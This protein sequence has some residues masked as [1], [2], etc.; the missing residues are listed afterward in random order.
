MSVWDRV[1]GQEPVIAEF[2][3]AVAGAPD[4]RAMTHAWLVTGPPG[5]GRSVAA[6]AFA[7]ALVCPSGGC[8][9]CDSC[10]SVAAGRH[11]DVA[12]V[13]PAGVIMG[14]DQTRALVSR[15][16]VM[17]GRSDWNVVVIEDADRLNEHADNALLKSLE[18]PPDHGVW[19]LC[20]PSADD[21]LPTIR[22]RCRVVRLRTPPIDEVARFLRDSLGADPALAAYAARSSQGHIGRARAL[23]LD[24]DARRQHQVVLH[25]PQRLGSVAACLAAAGDLVAAARSRAEA[26]ADPL[27][28]AEE[29]ELLRAYGDG[30]TGA[31]SARSRAGAALKELERDQ[32]NRRRRLVRDELDRVLVDLQGLYRD[33]LSVAVGGAVPLINEEAR[34]E[35]E[36]LAA[37]TDGP[38]VLERLD[39]IAQARRAVAADGSEDLVLAELTLALQR[40]S[41]Q[42]RG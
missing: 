30:A 37:A 29:A 12:V 20:A 1:V 26:I 22:S 41:T 39:A 28:A 27:D 42:R 21:V 11:S 16:A 10:A 18:E 8:G 33:V 24:A 23:V 32:R 38:G 2:R 6:E 9:A 31:G 35:V 13:K 14:V 25:L 36:Q 17:P 4:N 7:T 5:S 34:A 3:R 19:I 15:I 40:P